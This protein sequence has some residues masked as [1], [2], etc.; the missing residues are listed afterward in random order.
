MITELLRITSFRLTLLY[1]GL[2][3]L[4]VL[5]LLGFVYKEVAGYQ[6]Q[7]V[8]L[9]LHSEAA[10]FSAAPRADL[11]STIAQEIARDFRH[12]NLYGW[13][14]ADGNA[15][16][17][18]LRRVPQGLDLDG[19]VYIVASSAIPE[20][21]AG[22]REVR[23]LG[24][25]L[26]DGTTLVIGR[27]VAL[28]KEV[29]LA[30]L[31]GCFLIGAIILA[32]GALGGFFYSLPA[33]R[34][35][36]AINQATRRIADGDYSQRLPL[37]KRNHDLDILAGIVNAMLDETERLL[38]EV[39]SC[40][41][42]IAHDLRTP[43]TRLRASI[44]RSEQSVADNSQLQSMLNHALTQTDLLLTRFR[45]LSRISE[46]ESKRRHAGFSLASLEPIL[47]QLHGLYEPLANQSEV[48]LQLSIEPVVAIECDSEL[49]FEAIGNLIDNAIKFT[50]LGGRVEVG[51]AASEHGPVIVVTDSGPG[52][53]PDERKSVRQRFYRVADG[54]NLPGSGLGLS[55]VEAI[56]RLHDFAFVLDEAASGGLRACLLCWRQNAI[57]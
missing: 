47:R 2:F 51:L 27:D 33:V 41:D 21:A 8:E 17:G 29:R 15:L 26:D 13:F 20:F 23:A 3:A 40:S 12:I 10:A 57:V 54:R 32:L 31:R 16:A 7:Q 50:P 9:I 56:T 36:R 55:L 4:A 44:Y 35:I 48:I 22:D 43:L 53:P 11:R 5:G 30:L 25:H 46:I 19:R 34:H 37:G 38:G 14:A 6:Y 24:E 49:L 1:G 42:N 28:L 39:K 52:I 18:N 45:A